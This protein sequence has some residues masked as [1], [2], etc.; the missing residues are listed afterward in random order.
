MIGKRTG[1]WEGSVM[2]NTALAP[3]PPIAPTGFPGSLKFAGPGVHKPFALQGHVITRAAVA[4]KYGYVYQE[5]VFSIDE[6][7]YDIFTELDGRML[8]VYY[9]PASNQKC[10][11]IL[12]KP[13]KT[14]NTVDELEQFLKSIS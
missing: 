9:I 2:S 14:G 1:V 4:R 10:W 6:G 12:N 7:S 13:A 3:H 8:Y 11:W 5:S